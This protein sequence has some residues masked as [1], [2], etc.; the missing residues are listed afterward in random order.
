MNSFFEKLLLPQLTQME[1]NLDKSIRHC[2]NNV[3]LKYSC[4]PKL[5]DG[6]LYANC[7]KD[8]FIIYIYDITIKTTIHINYTSPEYYQIATL[9]NNTAQ[10]LYPYSKYP[11]PNDNVENTISYYSPKGIFNNLIEK[12]LHFK[13]YNISLSKSFIKTLDIDENILLNKCFNGQPI[14]F[15]YIKSVL[16][17]IF[18]TPVDSSCAALYYRGKILELL[19]LIIQHNKNSSLNQVILSKEDHELLFNIAKY[20]EKNYHN[21]IDIKT[22]EQ[23]FYIGRSKLSQIFKAKF[24]MSITE[25]IRNIRLNHAKNFLEN[26][27]LSILDIAKLVGYKNQGSF[28][29]FF[30]IETGFTPTQ[31]R[32]KT[33]EIFKTSENNTKFTI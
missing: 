9:N 22:L 11:Y 28:A 24:N 14:E 21:S 29:E 7:F 13:S 30:K 10:Y 31:F 23:L 12:N 3:E 17:Q 26:T 33:L 19:S 6:S 27:S 18:K 2:N 4:N 25:Y 5:G 20:L 15:P 16:D 1:M 32:R 8:L